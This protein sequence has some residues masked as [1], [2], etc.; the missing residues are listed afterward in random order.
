MRSGLDFQTTAADVRVEQHW[1]RDAPPQPS[2][3]DV[4]DMCD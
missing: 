1:A 4:E 3:D 2:D